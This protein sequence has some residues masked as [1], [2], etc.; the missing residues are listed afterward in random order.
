MIPLIRSITVVKFIKT[1][2]SDGYHGW[3]E[4]IWGVSV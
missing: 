2:W 4:G 1:K 3:E